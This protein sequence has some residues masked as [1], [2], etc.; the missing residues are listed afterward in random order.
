MKLPIFAFKMVMSVVQILAYAIIAAY[1]AEFFITHPVVNSQFTGYPHRG[2][3][4]LAGIATLVTCG[5]TFATNRDDAGGHFISSVFARVAAIGASWPF[6]R[7]AMVQNSGWERM[8]FGACGALLFVTGV[9]GIRSRS[10]RS[11]VMFYATVASVFLLFGIYL[12]GQRV[13]RFD[14]TNNQ[15][16]ST[17][18]T[19]RWWG[20]SL[21]DRQQLENVTGYEL[22]HQ[23]DEYG[24]MGADGIVLISPGG[25]GL[26]VAEAR[27][28]IHGLSQQVQQQWQSFSEST[29]RDLT[30]VE[31]TPAAPFPILLGIAAAIF[32]GGTKFD[33]FVKPP[34]HMP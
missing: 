26:F 32:Y 24:D 10:R 21:D 2:T 7:L 16:G 9:V 5:V 15:I 8:I 34:K 31:R 1:I 17:L 4:Y 3:F 25:Q 11:G 18:E 28:A 19:H 13:L 6:L 30:L 33:R 23:S 14:R 22:R 12:S 29:D 20:R 27:L